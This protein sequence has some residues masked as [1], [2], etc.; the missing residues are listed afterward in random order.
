MLDR[1]D[2]SN[3]DLPM[4]NEASFTVLAFLMGCKPS[5]ITFGLSPGRF[6]RFYFAYSG[7]HISEVI[8]RW[9]KRPAEA[10]RNRKGKA[11]GV[12]TT[13]QLNSMP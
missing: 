10:G 9:G 4:H 7:N 5:S 12:T 3:L 11:A 6:G 8:Q 2:I 13:S 1:I